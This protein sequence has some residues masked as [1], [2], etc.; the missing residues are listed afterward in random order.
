MNP[1]HAV[2]CQEVQGKGF[3]SDLNALLLVQKGLTPKGKQ[4]IG[5][6]TC[7]FFWFADT[8]HGSSAKHVAPEC[9]VLEHLH[10]TTTVTRPDVRVGWNRS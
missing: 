8:P 6:R 10:C 3:R 9:V 4:G 7:N 2:I 1:E 5:H